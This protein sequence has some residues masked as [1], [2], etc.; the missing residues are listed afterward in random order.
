MNQAV[1]RH[2]VFGKDIMFTYGPYASIYTHS[3]HPETD[4]LI[5][6]S[7]LYFAL[8][9]GLAVFLCF[10]NSQWPLKLGGLAA[11]V[12]VMTYSGQKTYSHDA[13]FFYYCLL[14]G[15]YVFQQSFPEL[16]A[17]PDTPASRSK[18]DWILFFLFLP[19]GLLPLIKSSTLASCMGAIF[20]S[21]ASVLSKK[22]W[23]GAIIVCIAPLFGLIVFWN[24]SGQQVADLPAFFSSSLRIISGYTEAMSGNREYFRVLEQVVCYMIGTV[25]FLWGLSGKQKEKNFPKIILW[26]MFLLALFMGFKAGYT[27]PDQNHLPAA[28]AML[29]SV[30]FLVC[31]IRN[32]KKS[33]F[34]LFFAFMAWG[35]LDFGTTT[36]QDMAGYISETYVSSWN[37][38][39]QRITDPQKQTTDYQDAILKIRKIIDLPVLPGTTDLYSLRQSRL[40]ASGNSWNPRP[41]FQSYSA[42][43]DFLIEENKN[44]LLGGRAP[45]NLFFKIEAIDDRIPSLDDGASWPTIL[46]SYEPVALNH[47][48]LVL[49]KRA[50][51]RE[52]QES[53]L[54]TSTYNLGST[55]A[56][57]DN[58]GLIFA[59]FNIRKTF[60]GKITETLFRSNHLEILIQLQ[61]GRK[62]HY[63]VLPE[64]ARSGFLLSPLIKDHED[65]YCLYSSQES[66]ESNRVKSFSI[67]ALKWPFFWEKTYDV[68]FIPMNFKDSSH[69]N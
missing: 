64:I 42:Y 68:T 12:V 8:S 25:I 51:R 39:K 32:D 67:R 30:G 5:L 34:A 17:N 38:L 21:V 11:L 48:Y 66:L 37:G 18:H 19:L 54:P 4:G 52:L 13:I 20:L 49:K 61:N 47:D 9:F 63:M 65:F 6:W 23:R 43:T 60:L 22:K 40:F 50:F 3:Y 58:D 69:S 57:P 24:L 26:A 15:V 14:A 2:L 28:R 55:V 10:K 44:H 35:Y 1:A 7:A 27:R 46:S 41:V 59:K 53:I 29:I 62:F 56:L 31:V 36:P 33:F 45:D 16:V